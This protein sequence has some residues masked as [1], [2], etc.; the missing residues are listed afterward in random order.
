MEQSKNEKSRENAGSLQKRLQ[1]IVVHCIV[2]PVS[3]YR[4]MDRIISYKK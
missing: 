4:V 1:P 2:C 3:S